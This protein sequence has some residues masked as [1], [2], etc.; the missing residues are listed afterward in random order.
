[1]KDAPSLETLFIHAGQ[2][3]EWPRQYPT[4]PA[5]IPS[6]SF[7]TQSPEIM[8]AILG[9]DAPG[10]TYS[11]HANPTVK[12]FSEA[13]RVL[14][15]GAVAQAF[16]SGM[17]ALDAALF[18]VGLNPGDRLL[19]S[20]DLYGATMNLSEQVW[21]TMGIHVE[22]VDV[23]DLER[24]EEALLRLRPR[25]LVVETLSNP[26]MKVPDL[27][28]LIALAH[29]V[30]CKV[31]VDNTFAT[32]VLV[33]PLT[34]GA[35]LVVH[36][37]TKYLGGHGDAI[38]GVVVAHQGYESRLH[39]YVKIRGSVLSPFDAWLLLRGIKT[40][41]VRFER[42]CQ[43]AA[44]AADLLLASGRFHRVYY[45]GLPDHPSHW[46]ANAL[47]SGRGYGAVVT[48]DV[49]GGR[50]RIFHLLSR[51]TLVGSATT[52][53]DVY[54]LCLYPSIASHRNQSAEALQ[55]MGISD[56]T[57]RIAVGLESVDDIVDDILT[58]LD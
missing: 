35:D 33:R 34:L 37:A 30:E 15:G 14:E 9:G 45:P 52:V 53:G 20:R 6:T 31:I 51:L 19:L 5:I 16:S 28:R 23:T 12:A 36:S 40:L 55:A 11:R 22:T 2:G 21:G 25:G 8:D 41:G 17:A 38:G 48:V 18:S 58:A 10:F 24:T 13:V 32:P 57:L 26:L 3:H 43:N 56:E 29:R 39:Q 42:Q 44:E 4:A 27:S 47:F 54:T 1:M 7:R 50:A 46:T 49:P